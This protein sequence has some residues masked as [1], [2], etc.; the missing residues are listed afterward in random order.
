MQSY[1]LNIVLRVREDRHLGREQQSTIKILLW[2][3][4]QT[5]V[6]VCYDRGQLERRLSVLLGMARSTFCSAVFTGHYM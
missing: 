2:S 4:V 5:G 3:Q 6:S 1:I